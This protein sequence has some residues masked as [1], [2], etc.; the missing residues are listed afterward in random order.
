MKI[1]V[2]GF[3]PYQDYKENITEKIV[4]RLK[5]R[6]NL[7]KV[8]L[9]VKFDKKIFIKAIEEYKPDVIL[10]LGQHPKATK[11][12][13]ERRAINLKQSDKKE[14]PKK[15][16]EKGSRYRLVNLKLKEDKSAQVCY[17][18]GKYVC[19]YCMYIVSDL[20]N[21]NDIKFAFLHIPKDYNIAKATK[22]VKAKIDKICTD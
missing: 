5:T 14:K 19:N 4:K 9:P 17:D 16:E 13:I 7:Q 6:K 10:G 21:K 18:A 12:R 11:I 2:F 3:K 20:A 15:I 1:L 22:F 8:V